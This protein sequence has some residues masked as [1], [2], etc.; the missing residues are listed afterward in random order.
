M[1]ILDSTQIL[2]GRRYN[3]HRYGSLDYRRWNL[4]ETSYTVGDFVAAH[5]ATGEI[6]VGGLGNTWNAKR[7]LVY[8]ARRGMLT[9]LG[10]TI[11]APRTR[12]PRPVGALVPLSGDLDAYTFG[13]EI[14]CILP[15]GMTR[16]AAAAQVVLAGVDCR[17]DVY[18]HQTRT[19]WKVIT[20][21]SLGDYTLGAE[22]VS[23][24][25]RGQDG[26]AQVE[27]VCRALQALGAKVNKRCGFH[28]HVGARDRDV[29]FFRRLLVGY[30]VNEAVL[31]SMMPASRRGN[32]N[33]YC[34][35]IRA[36]GLAGYDDR[37]HL[38]RRQSDRFVKLNVA[39]YYRHGTVEF[40]QHAGTVEA[41]KATYWV[42][43]CLR[44]VALAV[45]TNEMPTRGCSLEGLL[46]AVGSTDDERTFF[47]NRAARFAAAPT[48]R[49]A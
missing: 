14:E 48:A 45:S 2:R 29:M 18:G 8:M 21:G 30:S 11:A 7:Y 1:E 36:D 49:A 31:D 27:K 37:D 16:A 22:F 15:R 23:P 19:W 20:D 40:R 41:D 6:E 5:N 34:K 13:C 10:V 46:T 33:Q 32:A 42:K 4:L 3:P 12:A 43:F 28:V 9:L 38:L 24:V 39:S 35:P 25:L 47:L 26:L 17:E 44:F